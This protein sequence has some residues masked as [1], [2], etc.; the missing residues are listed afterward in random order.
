MIKILKRA[1]VETVESF[2]RLGKKK[3]FG[4][5]ARIIQEGR[6]GGEVEEDLP[7]SRGIPQR[8]YARGAWDRGGRG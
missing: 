6:G 1:T 7:R 8:E 4:S 5:A 2:N 3:G